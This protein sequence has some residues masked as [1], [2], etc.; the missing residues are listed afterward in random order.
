MMNRAKNTVR[1]VLIKPFYDYYDYNKTEFVGN[2]V[3]H[4][5]VYGV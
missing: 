5:P 2:H 3:V 4:S 1:T